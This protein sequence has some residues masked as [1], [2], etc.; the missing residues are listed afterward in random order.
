VAFNKIVFSRFSCQYYLDGITE[1]VTCNENSHGFGSLKGFL[2]NMLN[3]KYS[4]NFESIPIPNLSLA[5][6]G[7]THL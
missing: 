4:S 6:H 2:Q 3:Y 5:S 1:V 7:D